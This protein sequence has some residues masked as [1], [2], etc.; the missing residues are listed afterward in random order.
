MVQILLSTY[1]GIKYLTPLLESLLAQDYPH[2]EVLARDDGSSDGTVELLCKY[3]AAHKNIKVIPGVN[4]GFAQ[5]FFKLLEISSPTAD[6]IALCDQDDVWQKDKVSR[7]VGFLSRCSRNTPAL[8]CSRVTVV[9][10]HLK[11]LGYSEVPR[12]GLSFRNA[13]IDCPQGLGCTIFLNQAARRLLDDFPQQVY[14]HDWWIYLVLSA[15]GV[16]IYDEEPRILYRK[17]ASNLFGVPTGVVE[18]WR[19]KIL[20]FKSGRYRLIVN[21]AEEFMRIYGSSLSDEHKWTLKSFLE[22]RKRFWWDRLR[23]VLSCEV[24]HQSTLEGLIL[25]MLFALNRL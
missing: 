2:V 6:Y 9:D 4:L 14:S 22:N 5:S 12:K 16:L 13:L 8:Y 7:S 21:Q 17:H 25:K 3:A 18:K 19:V 1:N 10:E 15:F 24:Y 20:R 11:P 23:Y